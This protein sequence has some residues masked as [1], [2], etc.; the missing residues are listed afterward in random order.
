MRTDICIL[1]KACE[2]LYALYQRLV[3]KYKLV[4]FVL[5]EGF[6]TITLVEYSDSYI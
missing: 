3:F 1:G 5:A 4:L 6:Y 2:R